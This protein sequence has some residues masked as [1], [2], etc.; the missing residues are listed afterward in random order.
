[1]LSVITNSW[2]K[3]TDSPGSI[4]F[5]VTEFPMDIF[6][7]IIFSMSKG[8]VKHAHVPDQALVQSK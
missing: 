3:R 5:L 4:K 2:L 1:M 8:N 6:E 7:M